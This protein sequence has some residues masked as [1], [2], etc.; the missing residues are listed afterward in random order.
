MLESVFVILFAVGFVTFILGLFDEWETLLSFIMCCVS[1]LFF[2][3]AWVGSLYIQVP[4]DTYYTET[5][6]GWVCLGLIIINV[7][8]ALV[9][10]IQVNVELKKPRY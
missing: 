10:I 6:L 9:S 4:S 8:G 7:I 5:A 2:I 3:I 1:I